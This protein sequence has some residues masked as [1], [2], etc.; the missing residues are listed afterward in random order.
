ML[1]WCMPDTKEREREKN[2]IEYLVYTCG[3]YVGAGRT[4]NDVFGF[5]L[6]KINIK[7]IFMQN[8]LQSLWNYFC[9]SIVA[10]LPPTFIRLHVGLI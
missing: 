9:V 7:T 3:V 8:N 1:Q 2:S 6:L 4:V 5:C 10:K